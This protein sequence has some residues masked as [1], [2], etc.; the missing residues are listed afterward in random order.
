MLLYGLGIYILTSLHN[1]ALDLKIIRLSYS[2]LFLSSFA[3]YI[4]ITQA[5]SKKIKIKKVPS[6]PGTH[7]LVSSHTL[8]PLNDSYLSAPYQLM[9]SARTPRLYF[10]G[11][12]T[13]SNWSQLSF[14]TA[15]SAVLQRPAA[16]CAEHRQ[17]NS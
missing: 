8:F 7:S 3:L 13:S 16:A 6:R 2:S 17:T 4:Y 15:S 11:P 10:P 14:S 5:V 9:L 12:L 1:R